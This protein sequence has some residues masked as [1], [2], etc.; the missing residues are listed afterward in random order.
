MALKYRFEGST[1]TR[2]KLSASKR[3]ARLKEP[4]IA[5]GPGLPERNVAYVFEK[6]QALYAAAPR[7]KLGHVFDKLKKGVAEARKAKKG[8]L[9]ALKAR[10]VALA[11]RIKKDYEE[12]AA[13]T[14]LDLD[15]AQL[16][17]RA[18]TKAPVLE[19]SV[20]DPACVYTLAGF[21]GSY[22]CVGVPLPDLTWFPGF[23]NN[24]SSVRAA[25]ACILYSGTWFGGAALVLV[26][27]PVIGIANL[28]LVAPTTGA[29]ANFNNITSSVYAYLY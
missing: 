25:G 16:F 11:R 14:G 9:T 20:F 7:M 4:V 19:G 24:I 2:E 26:G 27:L 15:S 13:R 3:F 17:L 18:T 5:L 21:N 23:N 8:D 6:M 29:F 12:L 22:M 10:Q 28:A 1:Y